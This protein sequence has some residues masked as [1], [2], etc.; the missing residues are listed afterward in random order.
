MV[1]R[2]MSGGQIWGRGRRCAW[3]TAGGRRQADLGS[4]GAAVVEAGGGVEAEISPGKA[5]LWFWCC[6]SIT[7]GGR[8][9]GKLREKMDDGEG[10]GR[11]VRLV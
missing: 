2:R 7:G 9:K 6:F 10:K 4:V 11:L 5:G 1:C 8:V 3:A